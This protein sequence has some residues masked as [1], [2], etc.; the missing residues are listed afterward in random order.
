METEA[1]VVVVVGRV[2]GRRWV[3]ERR[4][5]VAMCAGETASVSRAS[6]HLSLDLSRA[7]SL[8]ASLSLSFPPRRD[9]LFESMCR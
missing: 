3:W 7:L 9:C 1:A 2:S 6:V 5:G 4:T 8:F